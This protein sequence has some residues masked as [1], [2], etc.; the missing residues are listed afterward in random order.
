ML[1]FSNIFLQMTSKT[2][3]NLIFWIMEIFQISKL[4]VFSPIY[5]LNSKG[6]EM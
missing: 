1:V 3:L 4:T 2:Y 6:K 5:S